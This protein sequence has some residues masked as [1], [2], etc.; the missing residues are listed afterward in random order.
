[1]LLTE[2]TEWLSRMTLIAASTYRIDYKIFTATKKTSSLSVD[3]TDMNV[4]STATI[5]QDRIPRRKLAKISGQIREKKEKRRNTREV[6][7]VLYVRTVGKW[8]LLVL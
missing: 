5:L 4:V 7:Q 1:M 2:I 8:Q 6:I 3:I